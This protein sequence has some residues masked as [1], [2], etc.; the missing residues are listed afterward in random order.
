MSFLKR[1]F[2]YVTRKR[3]KSLLLFVILLVMAT[4]VL[5]GISI[6]KASEA[7][8]RELRRNLGGTFQLLTD[9]SDENPHMHKE[10]TNDNNFIW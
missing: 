3:G 9:Y 6:W 5:T 8:Q 1:A 10:Q 2:L 7:M 4:F